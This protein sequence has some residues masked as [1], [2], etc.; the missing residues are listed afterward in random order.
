MEA[1]IDTVLREGIEANY[2]NK[3]DPENVMQSDDVLPTPSSLTFGFHG[4]N[5]WYQSGNFPNW[6]V[7]AEYDSKPNDTSNV[8]P[9]ILHE[10][11]L[12]G[13]N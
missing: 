3:P 12:H 5:P 6:E 9:W 7:Q 11:V 1:D 4:V 10:V 2:D 13:V 8:P